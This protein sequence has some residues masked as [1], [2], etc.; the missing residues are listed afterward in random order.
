MGLNVRF[1]TLAFHLESEKS[2]KEIKFIEL[3]LLVNLI[4]AMAENEMWINIKKIKEL[5]NSRQYQSAEKKA[6]KVN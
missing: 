3:S 5:I 1:V 4:P 6:K 2:N